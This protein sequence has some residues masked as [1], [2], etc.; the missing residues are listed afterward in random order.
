MHDY[1]RAIGF[2]SIHNKK[3]MEHL[4]Q[5]VLARPDSEFDAPR[6][7]QMAAFGEKTREFLPHTGIAVRGEIDD[8]GRFMYEYDFPY[9]TGQQLSLVHDISLEKM[10]DREDYTGVGYDV[11]SYGVSLVFH[12]NRLRDYTDSIA[13]LC[14]NQSRDGEPVVMEHLPI[15]LSALSISG[16]VLLP[17]E[18]RQ[19]KEDVG[20]GDERSRMIA[21]ARRGDQSAIENLTLEDID[22]YALISKRLKNEDIFEIVDTS[23]MPYG[24]SCDH[25]SI[26]GDILSCQECINQITGESVYQMTVNANGVVLDVCINS[27]DLL[28]EPAEGRRFRGIVWL[29]GC[30]AF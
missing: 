2:S 19:K 17:L 11:T 30:R 3:D 6:C 13:F 26:L 9:I 5:L 22:M 20:G 10:A 8:S 25:Y 27:T 16:T 4:V 1:L 29:Q 12:M 18:R 7:G 14:E 21:A 24:I 23:F 15:A 28:G